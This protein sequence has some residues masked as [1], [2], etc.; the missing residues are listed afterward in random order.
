MVKSPATGRR[1]ST[2][3]PVSR[4]SARLSEIGMNLKTNDFV[5]VRPLD[6]DDP[7]V[8]A[9]MRVMAAPAKGVSHG[10]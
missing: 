9:K 8:V 10:G 7:G 1:A 2:D 3:T 4:N 6:P 5:S